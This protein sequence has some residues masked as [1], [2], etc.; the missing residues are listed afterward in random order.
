[1]VKGL[2]RLTVNQL[3]LVRIQVGEQILGHE[4]ILALLYRLGG[5]KSFHSLLDGRTRSPYDEHL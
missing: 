3:F 5:I 2:S 4:K 1:M